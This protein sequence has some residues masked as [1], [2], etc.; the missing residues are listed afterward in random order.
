MSSNNNSAKA[1]RE[2]IPHSRGVRVHAVRASAR[3]CVLTDVPALAGFMRRV[4]AGSYT[5]LSLDLGLL[6][7]LL[8][9]QLELLFATMERDRSGMLTQEDFFL[10]DAMPGTAPEARKSS[11]ETARAALL[12]REVLQ[13]WDELLG[14]CV[15]RTETEPPAPPASHRRALPLCPAPAQSISTTTA[16]SRPR[17]LS[18]A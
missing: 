4:A 6:K 9:L 11:L 10:V 5:N 17:S 12:Q 1:P 16:R 8:A 7:L 13:R 15:P 18:T 2:S 14:E 3:P